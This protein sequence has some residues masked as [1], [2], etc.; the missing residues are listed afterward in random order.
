MLKKFKSIYKTLLISIFATF[1]VASSVSSAENRFFY[2]LGAG[3]VEGKSNSHF[4]T[5]GSVFGG[6]IEGH[7]LD[8][9]IGLTSLIKNTKV[10]YLLSY[11]PDALGNKVDTNNK[12]PGPAWDCNVNIKDSLDLGVKFYLPYMVKNIT[13]TAY[14]G[15]SNADIQLKI[16]KR[17]GGISN[18]KMNHQRN[19]G[20]TAGMGLNYDLDN[21]TAISFDYSW[22][23]Y[24]K[25]AEQVSTTSSRSNSRV[26][27]NMLSLKLKK[28][29]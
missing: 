24:E 15:V 1:T 16:F 2:Q 8:F 11:T 17:T 25:N 5:N 14:L 9:G 3:Y 21:D 20:G 27:I 4:L 18:G 22:T 6:I 13:P 26:E 7:K 23:A 10:D 12:C 19:W 28:Y 29:F